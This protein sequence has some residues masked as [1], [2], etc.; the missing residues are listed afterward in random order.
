MKEKIKYFNKN[1]KRI[2]YMSIILVLLG[3]WLVLTVLYVV[4]SDTS[5]SIWSYG[6]Q[7]SD[8]T[9]LTFSPLY[10]GSKISGQFV[11]QDK[12]L[13]IVSVRFQT[14]IRPP[15]S[16]EDRYLF[17]IK[18]KSAKQW[19]Y[20][21][22]YRSG[23]IYEIPFF[24]FG[25]PQI[26][27]SKGKSYQFE[28]TSLNGNSVNA[29]EISPSEPI[30]QSKYKYSGHELLQNKVELIKFLII[31][32]TNAFKTPDVIFSSFIYSLPL[33][34]YITWILFLE[35]STRPITN[36]LKTITARSENAFVEPSVRLFKKMF[37]VNLD[38]LV[39]LLVLVDIL[40]LQLPNDF[41]YLIVAVL[42][43]AML[44]IYK[45][46][47]KKTFIVGVAFI[48]LCPLFLTFK[49]EPIAEQFGAWAF[50]FLLTGV[51]Q[52]FFEPKS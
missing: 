45:E 42:W 23:F 35:K 19:Y 38:Y 9:K 50:M 18:E 5:F 15:F 20:T 39:V 26:A 3:L 30:L 8:F 10:K 52:L 28:I 43:I 32:F 16:L 41:V 4:N 27:D 14:F 13:G 6:H 36:K 34:L 48:A 11:A 51:I 31:K 47:C 40:I 49:L 24:P 12:N 2:I 44:K 17:K 7:R 22:I 21:N 46:N 37:I 25:F 29:L 1:I 33:I